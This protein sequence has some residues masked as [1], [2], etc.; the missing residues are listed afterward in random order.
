MHN[1]ASI[2]ETFKYYQHHHLILY[3]I[4]RPSKK[5]YMHNHTFTVFDA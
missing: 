4:K 2:I 1:H 3:N 5:Y